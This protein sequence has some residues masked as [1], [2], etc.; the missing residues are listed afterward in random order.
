MNKFFLSICIAFFVTVYANAQTSQ[1]NM[2][3]G[4]TLDFNSTSYQGGGNN[5]FSSFT[6]SP[7]FAYFISDQF[8]VG[9]SLTIG[10]ARSGTGPGKSIT[11]SF[12]LG[13]FARYY[14][15]TSNEKFAFFAQVAIGFSSS[16][17]DPP[18]GSVTKESAISFRLSPGA[19][20]F[21]NEHWA[22]ELSLLGL[23]I[24]SYDPNTGNGNDKTSSFQFGL[25]SL[26][27]SLGFH[28]HF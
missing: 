21:V 15:F 14:K 18:V 27:P 9:T 20:F 1:G 22:I 11:S 10:S 8:A 24:Q 17:T 12:G 23:V 5:D 6:L 19:A 7:S 13:P 3:A 25:S 28:Y 4:G 2:M 26:S 16:R